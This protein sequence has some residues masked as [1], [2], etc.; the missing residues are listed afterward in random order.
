MTVLTMSKQEFGRLDV[1]LRV[2]SGRLRVED[3]CALIGLQRRQIFRLLRGLKAD[4]ITSLLSKRRGKPGNL[5]EV[6]SLALSLVR[7]RYADFG[8]TFAAEKLAEQHGCPIS[9]ETLRG[10]MIPDGLWVDR[11][12]RLASPHQPRRRRQVLMVLSH[13]EG[14]NG[15]VGRYLSA[16]PNVRGDN[17]TSGPYERE[18]NVCD[19]VLDAKRDPSVVPSAD[20]EYPLTPDNDIR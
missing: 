13:F 2:Q 5:A 1:L 16:S 4:G 6:R 20:L 14:A 8:P 18:T 12:H 3:A 7:E 10:W 17:R 9:R 19:P 15:Q 11:R